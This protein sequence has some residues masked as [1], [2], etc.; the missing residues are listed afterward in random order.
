MG[1]K[2]KELTYTPLNA[3]SFRITGGI[4]T[5]TPHA[6]EKRYIL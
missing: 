6:L 1:V 4:K 2:C 3:L 5:L